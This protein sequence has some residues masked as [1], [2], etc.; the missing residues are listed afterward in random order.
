MRILFMFV[1]GLLSILLSYQTLSAADF[2]DI[3]RALP[4]GQYGNIIISRTTSK[5]YGIK[6]VAFSHW[7]HRIKYTCRVCHTELEFNFELNSTEIT[8]KANR[9]GKFCGACHNG[10][11]A[12]GHT[13]EN[14]A[15][16]HSNDLKYGG[17]DFKGLQKKLPAAGFGNRINWVGA[18]K[19]GAIKPKNTI[20]GNYEPMSYD[21]R[22]VLTPEWSS[23][24]PAVMPHKDHLLWL[25]CSNCHPDIFDV[26][27]RTTKHFSMNRILK[28][29]FCGVCHLRTAFPL[30]DCRRCHKVGQ[31]ADD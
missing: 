26:K 11:E 3:P 2:F 8:E 1:P 29:E 23:I 25:D 13:D 9:E 22:V 31:A 4:P 5:E 14:C 30:D 20:L 19:E 15:K 27:K 10:K 18:I 21:K 7:S 16:C 28:F 24:P 12:F 6:P 17:E